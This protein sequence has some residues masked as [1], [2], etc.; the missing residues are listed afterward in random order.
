MAIP[1]TKPY[2]PELNRNAILKDIDS[3]LSG[4][5]LITGPFQEKLESSFKA[6]IGLTNAVALNSCTS[7]LT[8]CLKY[9]DIK[10]REVLVPSGTFIT[11]VTSI[12]F[13]GGSPVLVDINP[14][15]LSFDLDDLRK[16]ITPETKGIVWV[17]LTGLISGE[18]Q[19]LLKIARDNNLFVLEDCAHALGATAHGTPA[20]GLGDAGCFSFYP[21]KIITSGTGGLI[22]TQ[23]E[24]LADF[25]RSMRSFGKTRDTGDLERLGGDCFLDEFRACIAYHQ[26]GQLDQ[27]VAMRRKTAEI[28]RNLLASLPEISL[29]D[30]PADILSSYYQFPIYLKNKE[31][32]KALRTSLIESYGI[33]S[34]KIYRPCHKFTVLSHLNDGSLSKTEDTLERSLCLPVFPGLDD[35]DAVHI[36]DCLKK[37]L[38]VLNR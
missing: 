21:T 23:N 11:S 35:A 5:R 27:M 18:Y 26:L 36:V 9:F 24:E 34:K 19:E 10:E 8:I 25:A 2:F 30:S 7:A 17:H 3:I 22:A 28:Y 37:E 33:E 20:G 29:P 4:G 14:K 13:A 32:R 16:K 1:L 31:V 38:D 6:K 15:T 12:L